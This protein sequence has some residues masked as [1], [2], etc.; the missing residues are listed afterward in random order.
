MDGLI[1]GS[2]K[3]LCGQASHKTEWIKSKD[4]VSVRRRHESM[5]W[6]YKG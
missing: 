4:D 5:L 2:D 3:I 1:T 6:N